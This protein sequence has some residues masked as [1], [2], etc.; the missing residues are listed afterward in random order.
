MNSATFAT[1]IEQGVWGAVIGI[2]GL[3]A[4][5]IIS[6]KLSEII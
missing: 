2:A 4:V 1:A 6:S 5:L 3:F